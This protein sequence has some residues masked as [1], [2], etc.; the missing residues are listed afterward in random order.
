MHC[1]TFASE[2]AFVRHELSAIYNPSVGRQLC[3]R[4][5]AQ[6]VA[7]DDFLLRY[8]LC[9]AVAHH[10]YE[11]IFA[12]L[13]ERLERPGASVLHD[14]GYCDREHDGNNYAHALNP[15]ELAAR[16]NPYYLHGD[17]DGERDEQNYEHRFAQRFQN[18]LEDSFGLFA[19][20]LI[21]AVLFAALLHLF[22]REAAGRVYTLFGEQFACGLH[23]LLHKNLQIQF[24]TKGGKKQPLKKNPASPQAYGT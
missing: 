17:G 8:H 20:E 15:V 13:G 12:H 23:V 3:S 21:F 1:H 11:H 9:F 6:N 10:L 7:Y 16:A 14:D 22:G 24:A 19:R 18:S 5:Y 2:G 4:L